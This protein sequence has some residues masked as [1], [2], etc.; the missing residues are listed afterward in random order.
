MEVWKIIF[1]S[2]WVICR[3]HVNLPGCSPCIS[4]SKLFAESVTRCYQDSRVSICTKAGEEAGLSKKF[5][6]NVEFPT[7]FVG[8]M[9]YTP[10]N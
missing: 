1:L 9:R 2:K 8:S 5:G 7:N 3:F 4:F 10:I 6:K